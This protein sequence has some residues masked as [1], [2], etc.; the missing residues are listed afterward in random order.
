M[1]IEGGLLEAGSMFSSFAQVGLGGIIVAAIFALSRSWPTIVKIKSE[2]D[3]AVRASEAESR[4]ADRARIQSL[5]ARC[6]A[7][8]SKLDK[9][10][11]QHHEQMEE[12][13]VAHA[14]ELQVMRHQLSNETQMLDALLRQLKINPD[15]VQEAADTIIAERADRRRAIAIEKGAMAGRSLNNPSSNEKEKEKPKN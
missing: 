12:Q 7:L 1:L 14:A 3:A 13:R 5:E 2:G 8:S 11:E 15:R 4:S 10:T 9:L 6:D